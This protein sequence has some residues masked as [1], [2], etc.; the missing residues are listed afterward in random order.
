MSILTYTTSTLE[1]HLAAEIQLICSE[2]KLFLA[3]GT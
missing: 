1:K 3:K 2:T